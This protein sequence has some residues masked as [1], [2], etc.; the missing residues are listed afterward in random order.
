MKI[1]QKLHP[2]QERILTLLQENYGEPLSMRALQEILDVSS[3]S[4]V[5]HHILQ[6]EKKGYL[7]RN[8]A[9]PYDYQVLATN[10][11]R[12][13]AYLNV[14]G[15][16]QCGPNGLLLDGT[17]ID[18]IPIS[19]KILGFPASDA[20][21]VK[22]RGNSMLPKIKPGDLVI[23]KKTNIA[24][25]GDIIVCVNNGEVLIKK[26]QRIERK[27]EDVS[28]NLISLNH[29]IPAFLASEDFKIE[30]VVRSILT[31]HI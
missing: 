11:E 8:P 29:E 1:V 17:P 5:R 26:L 12:N 20:F 6:L 3:H 22:A 27:S 28:Y 18:R 16:A 10:P 13:I 7:R 4:V 2:V 23:S 19:S 25:N 9:N 14:Y 21:I 15:M 30:G 24:N 31:Y